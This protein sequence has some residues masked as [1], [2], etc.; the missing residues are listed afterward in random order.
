MTTLNDPN[1]NNMNLNLQGKK[2]PSLKALYLVNNG[3]NSQGVPNVRPQGQTNYTNKFDNPA[4]E[5]VITLS[6]FRQLFEVTPFL[7]YTNRQYLRYRVMKPNGSSVS[8]MVEITDIA[9]KAVGNNNSYPARV[10]GI[11]FGYSINCGLLTCTTFTSSYKLLPI[12]FLSGFGGT[13]LNLCN[14]SGCI[15]SIGFLCHLTLNE[16][17]YPPWVF[18][19]GNQTTAKLGDLSFLMME[20]TIFD[21]IYNKYYRNLIQRSS[22]FVYFNAAPQ[23]ED[24]N[25][26]DLIVNTN[27]NANVS[28]NNN[29]ANNNQQNINL[30][31]SSKKTPRSAK[32]NQMQ[33]N[34]NTNSKNDNNDDSAKPSIPSVANPLIKSSIIP[35]TSVMNINGSS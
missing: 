19:D 20:D 1:Q 15:K 8:A 32:I 16:K 25:D 3:S 35:P 11:G 26:T 13:T 28:N 4:F 23:I 10:L 6:K 7:A 27:N 30:P 12:N 9:S 17:T 34:N 18:P 2:R 24:A 33:N 22:P 5:F 21:E 31:S 14:L 29:N